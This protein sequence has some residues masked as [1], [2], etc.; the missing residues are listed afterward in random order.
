MDPDETLTR[1]RTLAADT[2]A[3][4]Y[5]IGDEPAHELA[6]HVQ[7]LDEW[8]TARGFLPTAWRSAGGASA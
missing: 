4:K 7:A 1:L 5:A 6:E 8:L 2:L 3:G